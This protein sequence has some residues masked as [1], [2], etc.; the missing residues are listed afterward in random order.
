[1]N[2]ILKLLLFLLPIAAAV[3]CIW[4]ETVNVAKEQPESPSAVITMLM[5]GDSGNAA[6]RQVSEALS[7]LTRERFGFS[8]SVK[9]IPRDKYDDQLNLLLQGRDAPDVCYFDM[10]YSLASYVYDDLL[11]PLSQLLEGF[12]D[13]KGCFCGH[14][15]AEKS[16][17]R[18]I[19]AIP[20][21]S[22]DVFAD[23][24][25]ARADILEQL[26]VRAEDITN[27]EQL[28]ALLRQVH[29]A[30]P[31]MATVVSDYGL[32]DL[33]FGYDFLGNGLGVLISGEGTQVVNLYATDAYASFC[34]AMRQ[35]NQE[36]LI[37]D[38]LSLRRESAG[39][40]MAAMDG[41]GFFC[42]LNTDSFLMYRRTCAQEL[43]PIILSKPVHTTDGIRAGWSLSNASRDKKRSMQLLELLYTDPQA[44]SIL[45]NGPGET[46]AEQ[47]WEYALP[48][49]P[50][51][52]QQSMF[53]WETDETM[54]ELSPACGYAGYS[55]IERAKTV[56]CLSASARYDRG[57][58]AG[59]LEP[60]QALPRL[61]QE[62]ESAGINEIMAEKQW[63]LDHFLVAKSGH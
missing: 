49:F 63:H 2:R 33:N 41:F 44:A 59:D 46:G 48:A 22:C 60:A 31:Q 32:L 25:L 57:L 23:G 27:L 39:A 17:F 1:M 28:H 11:Y 42:R 51:L 56:Q 30:Y 26:G 9:Q 55:G 43:V 7:Q 5:P 6:C 12:P 38:G 40:Q 34:A 15:W 62:L 47:S 3:L 37:P 8:V 14:Q 58:R 4:F 50:S 13:L 36:G 19:Y 54:V 16:V 29:E 24:F 10:S 20:C 52:G 45:V 35:W 61:L 18:T 53:S 21:G